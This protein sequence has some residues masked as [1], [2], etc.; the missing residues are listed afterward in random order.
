L[1]GTLTLMS[2]TPG[3]RPRHF[4]ISGTSEA[5]QMPSQTIVVVEVL[6]SS[7]SVVPSIT[8]SVKVEPTSNVKSGRPP[9]GA[10]CAAGINIPWSSQPSGPGWCSS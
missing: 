8:R 2:V 6:V 9:L 4:W 5:Q 3:R 1:V 7:G 10:D